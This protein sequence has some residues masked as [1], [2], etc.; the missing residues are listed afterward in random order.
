VNRAESRLPL[1]IIDAS[2]KV[3]HNEFDPNE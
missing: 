2:R 3:L 1:Q